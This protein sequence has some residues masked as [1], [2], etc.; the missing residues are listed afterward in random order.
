M[1]CNF[2]L[3]WNISIF[4][5]YFLDEIHKLGLTEVKKGRKEALR[6]AKKLGL[7]QQDLKQVFEKLR[8]KKSQKFSS[9]EEI[10][11]HLED[12]ISRINPKLSKVFEDD[13]VSQEILKV[14]ITTDS[15]PD[16]PMAKY[17]RSPDGKKAAFLV[18]LGNVSAWFVKTKLKTWI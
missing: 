2:F 1:F 16:A 12:L 6:A 5:G 14:N 4:Y 9:K 17:R 13:L 15:N 8:S 18:N 3:C 7:H 11:Q 10:M